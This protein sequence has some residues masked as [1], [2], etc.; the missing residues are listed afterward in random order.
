MDIK[1]ITLPNGQVVAFD[2]WLHWPNF[3]TVEVAAG[4]SFDL[5]AF[6]YVVGQNVPQ[7]GLTART[8]TESDTNQVARSRMNH[9]EGYICYSMTYEIFALEDA[10]AYGGGN[11]HTD[12][13]SPIF[14]G[15]NLRI[16][17]RRAIVELIV[18]AGITK[19]AAAGPLSYFGQGI[20]AWAAG[21]GDALSV[22]NAP[23]TLNLNYGTGGVLNP[24]NNQ[25]RWQIPVVI[26]GDRVMYVRLYTPDGTGVTGTGSMADL[27]QDFQLKWYMDGIK[28]RER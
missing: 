25:R 2:E 15:T 23:T 13:T 1:T 17:Q 7:A 10:P 19:P 14:A 18:G 28:R 11:A 4:T 24:R 16:L 9:D 5:R 6:S 21:S 8:S 27:N 12:A 22:T 20:G 26:P 3:S